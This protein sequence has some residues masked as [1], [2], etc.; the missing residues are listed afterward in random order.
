M[1]LMYLMSIAAAT[2]SIDLASAY[3]VPDELID[4]ALLAAR[5]RGVRVRILVPGQHTDSDAVRLASK[6]GW[7]P[8]LKSGMQIYEYSPTMMHTK[9]LI[10]MA[11]WSRRIDQFRYPSFRLMTRPA[12]TSTIRV[13]PGA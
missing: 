10:V 4:H 13:S 6:A 9:L 3:F 11:R 12:S 1:H 8:L 2:E 7:G 5:R